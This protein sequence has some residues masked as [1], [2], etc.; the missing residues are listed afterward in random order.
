MHGWLS[1]IVVPPG[2]S[3]SW[4]SFLLLNLV[5]YKDDFPWTKKPKPCRWQVKRVPTPPPTPQLPASAPP[6]ALTSASWSQPFAGSI[7]SSAAPKRAS[8]WVQSKEEEEEE[9]ERRLSAGVQHE[10]EEEEE[11]KEEE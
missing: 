10:E 7:A 2:G 4:V 1:G 3:G 9:E 6:A 5:G 8:T 11:D